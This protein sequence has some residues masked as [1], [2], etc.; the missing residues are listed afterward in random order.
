VT[1]P[2]GSFKKSLG[3]F[4]F[5]GKVGL[6]SVDAAIVPLDNN[7]YVFTIAGDGLNLAGIANPVTVTLQIGSDTGTSDAQIS[8]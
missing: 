4:V 8:D 7:S 5:N 1:I 2:A 6:V 3:F